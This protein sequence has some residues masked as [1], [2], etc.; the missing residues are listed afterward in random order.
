MKYILYSCT[1]LFIRTIIFYRYL[2][3]VARNS[4]RKSNLPKKKDSN[5]SS[6]HIINPTNEFLRARGW[7]VARG[8]KRT[9]RR[10]V[11]KR[12]C[13]GMAAGTLTSRPMFKLWADV[14][15]R[16]RVCVRSETDAMRAPPQ[17]AVFQPA[18]YTIVS[19]SFARARPKP[20]FSV[21]DRFYFPPAVARQHALRTIKLL[22]FFLRAG[23]VYHACTWILVQKAK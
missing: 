16:F 22:D 11:T 2:L 18:Q 5:W 13:D 4:F 10:N 15:A 14:E 6:A 19:S 23:N 9:D 20:P 17:A 3:A 12:K 21:T 1:H 7:L 8:P